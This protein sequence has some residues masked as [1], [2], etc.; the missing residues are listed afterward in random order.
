MSTTKKKL[1]NQF[2]GAVAIC[3]GAFF[4]Q[5]FFWT[6]WIIKEKITCVS[7]LILINEI[8]VRTIQIQ[9]INNSLLF[10]VWFNIIV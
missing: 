5:A 1:V 8:K 9:K 7:D 4:A 10:S 6:P 3:E 2:S